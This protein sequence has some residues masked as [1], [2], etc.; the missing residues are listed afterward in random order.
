MAAIIFAMAASFSARNSASILVARDVAPPISAT[1]NSADRAGKRAWGKRYIGA[2]FITV[3]PYAAR[4][5]LTGSISWVKRM[6]F[7]PLS[8]RTVKSS[9]PRFSR[10]DTRVPSVARRTIPPGHT[11][12]HAERQRVPGMSDMAVSFPRSGCSEGGQVKARPFE[13]SAEPH[14]TLVHNAN[15]G[16]DHLGLREGVLGDR[17]HEI[18]E[19]DARR[20]RCTLRSPSEA[21]SMPGRRTR[22]RLATLPR[23]S[24]FVPGTLFSADLSAH[25]PSRR[26]LPSLR[27]P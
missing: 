17:I 6:S 19:R 3:V 2:P 8:K 14:V 18:E 9:R 1:A 24:G 13:G 20:H 12:V 7:W 11:M 21:S 27:P 10:C 25:M 16:G 22:F 5:S 15:D 26:Q 4:S 23:R